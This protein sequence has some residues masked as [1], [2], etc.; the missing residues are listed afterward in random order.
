MHWCR[1][2]SYSRSS[3]SFFLSWVWRKPSKKFFRI[4][5]SY[6]NLVYFLA[7]T[8]EVLDDSAEQNGTTCSR[9]VVYQPRREK[10]KYKSLRK[11]HGWWAIWLWWGMLI[12]SWIF[13]WRLFELYLAWQSFHFRKFQWRENKNCVG[14]I[15]KV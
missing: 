3:Y 10:T 8:R 12:F 4:F 11:R 2:T 9:R 5:L 15:R 7:F 6:A 13:V 1:F 14:G